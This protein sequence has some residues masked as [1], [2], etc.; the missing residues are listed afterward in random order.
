MAED[1][2]EINGLGPTTREKLEDIG[3]ETVDQ[4]ARADPEIVDEKSVSVSVGQMEKFVGRAKQQAIVIETGDEVRQKYEDRGQVPTG[5][6]NVDEAIDG[7]FDDEQV[8]A[9]GGDTGS[10][11]TQMAFQALGN[12]VQET[13]ERAVY[14]ETEPNRYQGKRIADMFDEGTQSM[15]DKISVRGDNALDQ[16]HRAYD[17]LRK[18]YDD[19]SMIVVDSFTSRFRLSDDFDGRG[20]LSERGQE[21]KRH[22][23]AI[24]QLTI[25][26]NCP[27]L[28]ICQVYQDPDPYSGQDM[29]LYGSTLMMHMVG[30]VM[31]MRN[32]GGA[33]STLEVKNHPNEGDST[34]DIQIVESGVQ[35]PE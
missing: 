30:F 11:K 12:A 7:G 31:L 21:F 15:V 3:I 13:D 25:E 24:E 29:V 2:E 18:R 33:L 23:K 19:L 16:Q 26:H 5:I 4:L 6:E 17:A 9:I 27:V 14:I 1:L 34:L 32:E 10:G 22:L 20:Q 28:L 8:V 35:E